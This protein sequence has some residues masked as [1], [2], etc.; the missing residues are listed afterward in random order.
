MDRLS[1]ITMFNA[2]VER[3]SFTAAA[4]ALGVSASAVSKQVSQLENELGARLI[5][6]TTR[7]LSLTEVGSA[8]YEQ[9]KDIVSALDQAEATVTELT[10][11]PRG[12]LKVHIPVGFGQVHLSR[13]L[14]GFLERYP[15]ITLDVTVLESHVDLVETGLDVAVRIGGRQ[16][17]SLIRRRLAPN[18]RLLCASPAYLEAHGTPETPDDLT[19]HNCLTHSPEGP[20]GEWL[21]T[22]GGHEHAVRLRGTVRTNSFAVLRDAALAGA[23]IVRLAGY[24]VG[25]DLRA[26][27]L[28]TVLDEYVAQDAEISVVYPTRRHLSPKVRAFVDYLVETIG[29]PDFWRHA[30]LM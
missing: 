5:N 8:Y 23:G 3:Q 19:H 12:L 7:S 6:R 18:R 29:Q 13:I 11:K 14:P 4:R 10:G 9:T 20:H 21:F 2:V 30:G 17:S 22:D 24:L 28:V 15:E 25:E 27:R 1:Q 16:D 26:G